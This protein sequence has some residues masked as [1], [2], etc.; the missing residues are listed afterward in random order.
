MFG[1]PSLCVGPPIESDAFGRSVPV[2]G[3]GYARYIKDS[4]LLIALKHD[5]RTTFRN[6]TAVPSLYSLNIPECDIKPQTIGTTL[7]QK[8]QT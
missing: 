8:S 6:W 4:Y 5:G 2:Q 7:A 3:R 1:I